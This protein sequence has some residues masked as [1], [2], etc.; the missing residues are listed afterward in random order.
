MKTFVQGQT[1]SF[2]SPNMTTLGQAEKKQQH[3]WFTELKS[4]LE[5]YKLPH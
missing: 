3:P 2:K 1:T 5:L 4:P